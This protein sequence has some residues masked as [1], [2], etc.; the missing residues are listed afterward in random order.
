MTTEFTPKFKNLVDL[1]ETSVKSFGPRPLFGTKKGDDWVWTTYEE[2]G[3]MVDDFRGGLAS[4]GVGEGDKVAIIANNRVEW[5]VAAYATYGLQAAFVPMYEAQLDKEWKFII[6]DCGAKVLVVSSK[7]IYDRV[8]KFPSEIESLQHVVCLD[9]GD[10]T[11][12]ESLCKK[13]RE[14]PVASTHPE[15]KATA[16]LIYTSGTTGNPKGVVLS[17]SNLASNVSAMQEIIPFVPDDRSLS[18]LPWAHSFGQT[19]ELHGMISVGASMGLAESTEKIVANLAEVQ[20]TILMSVP[21]IFNKIYDG[22]NKQMAEKPAIIQRIFKAGM[23]CA[24]KRKKGE[25][26]TF[27]EGLSLWIARRIIFSKIIAKFGG[28]LKYAVSGGAALNRDVA[29]F[30]DNLGITVYEGY[31]LTET[32]PITTANTER[33]RRIGSVGKPIP[34][35]RVE[36]DTAAS[37]DPKHGEIVV[38]GHNVMQGYHNLPEENAKVLRDDGGFRT[39]DLGYLDD[40]GFLWITGRIKEQYKLE[41]GKYVV[42]VPLEEQLQ[43]SPYILQAVVHGANRPYN[44][45]LV[46]PD[47]PALR[48]WAEKN[49]VDPEKVLEDERARQLLDQEIATYSKEFKAFERVGKFAIVS[50]EFTTANDMLTPSLKLKRKNVLSKYDKVIGGLY[51]EAKKKTAAASAAA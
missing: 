12:F 45:A 19:V 15:G 42:P 24:T 46:V 16:G 4:L 37:G 40:D 39:G 5:A 34:G 35:V 9:A 10:D 49:G 2:L 21:R 26:T 29:E 44:I 41:N 11:G 48:S 6:E 14:K 1:V 50:E 3:R 20:P 36:I 25:P 13:G 43:L 8:K 30:I 51:A 38:L 7:A 27:G 31:G 23:R 33:D 18:F 17:H 22:V 28:R 32:S 47:V